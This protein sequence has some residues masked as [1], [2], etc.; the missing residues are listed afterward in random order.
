MLHVQA[1]GLLEANSRSQANCTSAMGV[2]L[3]LL[4]HAM[5]GCVLLAMVLQ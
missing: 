5:Q 1:K 3:S 2:S 4:F